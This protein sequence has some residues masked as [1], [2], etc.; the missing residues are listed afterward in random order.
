MYTVCLCV[1]VCLKFELIGVGTVLSTGSEITHIRALKEMARLMQDVYPGAV[2]NG[3]EWF[4]HE[5]LG[6]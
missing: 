3:F 6:R 4:E 2:L 5:A 1:F